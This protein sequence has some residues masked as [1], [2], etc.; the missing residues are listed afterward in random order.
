MGFSKG[1]ALS[2][3]LSVG[4]KMMS[5]EGIFL[6]SLFKI[7]FSLKT[8]LLEGKISFTNKNVIV[9]KPFS[10]PVSNFH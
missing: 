5:A 2:F 1:Q 10:A 6:P 8:Y 9:S 3:I 7:I 4:W